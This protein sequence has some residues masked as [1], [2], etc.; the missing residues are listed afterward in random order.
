MK[1]IKKIIIV[2]A[3]SLSLISPSSIPVLNTTVAV[4][5]A[6]SPKMSASKLTL[7]VG[8]SKTLTVKNTK[9]TPTWKSSKKS[10]A[11]VSKKGKVTAKA[12]GTT[13]ITATVSGKK[14]TCKVTVKKA[15][16][17]ALKKAPF[18]A[19]EFNYQNMNMVIPTTWATQLKSIDP[20][21]ESLIIYPNDDELSFVELVVLPN[22]SGLDNDL[23][24]TISTLFTAEYLAEETAGDMGLPTEISD[25]H[26]E[27]YKT[28]TLSYTRISYQVNIPDAE[29]T[30]H[31]SLYLFL[32]GD[33]YVTI[34]VAD[35]ENTYDKSPIIAEAEYVINS[36]RLNK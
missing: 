11:T 4:A 12:P 17:P 8:K 24:K 36:I 33:Y 13:T 5:E 1:R 19:M 6:A 30:Y 22:D 31:Q 32:I 16:N 15:A 28:D 3:L 7:E 21:A 14:Y 25:H 2:F 35:M 27:H 18:K 9:K 20:D 34:G 23:L 10:V 29:A 26:I